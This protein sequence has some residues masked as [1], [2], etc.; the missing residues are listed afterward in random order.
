MSTILYLR[1]CIFAYMYKAKATTNKEHYYT[2]V[3][4]GQ[5]TLIA[6]ESASTGGRG[7]GFS[8]G[9]LLASALATCVSITVRMYAD[10][11]EWPLE[12]IEVTVTL[13]RDEFQDI[14]RFEKKVELS[15]PLE[16]DQRERLLLIAD[17]CPVHKYLTHPLTIN[18]TAV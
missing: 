16:A 17:K 3:A 4:A 1:S 15:G 2:E 14:T 7:K 18:T 10:K 5:N 8:P 9:E 12:N 6:D 13:E 11:K